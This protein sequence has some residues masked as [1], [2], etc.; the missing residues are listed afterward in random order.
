MRSKTIFRIIGLLLLFS[1]LGG[2]G[3]WNKW[4]KAPD[5]SRS[6]PE[7]LYQEGVTFYQKND[8]LKAVE[9]FQALKEEHPLSQYALLAE[10]GIA[11]SYYSDKKYGDAE[12]NYSDFINLH[13]TNSNIPYAMYQIGICH[14]EQMSS[15]DRDQT[16]TIRA[17]K[18]FEKLISR[19]PENKFSVMAE[20]ALRECKR[21]LAEHEFYVGE[22]YF[23]TSRY[24]AALKRFELIT[25]EYAN[26]GLDYKTA[27]FINE[28]KKRLAEM[29]KEEKLAGGKKKAGTEYHGMEVRN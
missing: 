28:S 5:Y 3:L 10:I 6:K 9:V 2:C 23:K 18:E 22:F 7:T 27:Y 11:D 8:Y 13:P 26:L 25:R 19:F 4:G 16:E 17:K 20:K 29:E 15:I 14:F 21:R 24:R 1:L 12:A